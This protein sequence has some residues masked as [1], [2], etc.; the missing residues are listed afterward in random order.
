[1]KK[2]VTGAL[3]SIGMVTLVQA[4]SSKNYSGDINYPYALYQVEMSSVA[5]NQD[6]PKGTSKQ[7]IR[8]NQQSGDA[9]MLEVIRVGNRLAYHWV[10][11]EDNNSYQRRTRSNQRALA[12]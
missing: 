3:L 1:M 4:A 9:E 8:I 7:V 11:V 5:L 2:I 6:N 10:D 12:L